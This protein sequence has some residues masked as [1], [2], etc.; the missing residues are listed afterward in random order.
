MTTIQLKRTKVGTAPTSLADG[1]C[2][3]DMLNG[4]IW[5][6][7]ASNVLHQFP[8]NLNTASGLAQLDS[9]GKV[10]LNNL[11]AIVTGAMTYQG[12]WNASTNN[13]SL[14]S[15]QGTKGYFYKVSVAGNTNL[16]GNSSWLVG[17]FAA[18]DGTQWDKFAGT[19]TGAI[20][21]QASDVLQGTDTSKFVS[22]A[23]LAQ[24]S[25][26]QALADAASIGWNMQA[27]FNALVTL[28]GNRSLAAPTGFIV[29]RTY[30]LEIK[31]DA[32]GS[33][34]LSFASCYDFGAAG[35]PVL[36]TAAGKLDL[37]SMI[38]DSTG[39]TFRCTFLKG[40]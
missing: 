27:G 35:V 30:T 3:I 12:S 4:V 25:A 1:E 16:D 17:D 37:V 9:N 21:A 18:F 20:A 6:K 23:S 40:F 36:S 22:S 31:Q 7:D 15:G 19:D 13:P 5:W 11:P 8:L 29:G 32:T 14:T 34:T 2:F 10:P 38:C 24:A 33:R 39:P 26:F 28:G